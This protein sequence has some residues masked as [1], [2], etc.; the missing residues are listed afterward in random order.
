MDGTLNTPQVNDFGRDYCSIIRIEQ[1]LESKTG[2]LEFT[3]A[4]VEDRVKS[5]QQ[6]IQ[7]QMES[8][9]AIP[10]TLAMCMNN[11]ILNL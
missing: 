8:N 10:P 7:S 6:F 4:T 1:N 3:E 2:Q 9:T 5:Q 11:M